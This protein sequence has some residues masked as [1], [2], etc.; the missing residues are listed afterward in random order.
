MKS[1]NPFMKSLAS[2]ANANG[3]QGH[4]FGPQGAQANPYAQPGGGVATATGYSEVPG[5]ANYDAPGRSDRPM[6]VD[7]VVTKTGITLAVIIAL[8]VLNYFLC[9]DAGTRPIGMLLTFVG[10]IGGLIAVFVSGLAKKY[11]SPVVTLTYAA[12][13]GLFIGGFS[14]IVAGY[15]VEGADAGAM[16]AQAL[17]G[18]LGV[19]AG[20]LFVYKTGAIRVTPKFTRFML[21]A[22][23]G[24]LVLA[25]GNLAYGLVV[26]GAG[27]LRDGGPVALVFSLACIGLAAMSFLLD[28]DQADKLVRA[29]APS[30]MAWGVAMGLAVTLVWTYTEILRLLSYFNRN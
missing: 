19:F 22:L 24:V 21:A 4:P 16:I 3:Y 11:D 15:L 26:G 12:F 8:A 28:F 2:P 20:M 9:L 13:E 25:L 14:F 6:T 5:A 29:G 17:L 7:D 18:T 23:I 10:M 1:S 30:R 27:P